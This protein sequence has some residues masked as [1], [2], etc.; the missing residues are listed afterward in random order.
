VGIIATWGASVTAASSISFANAAYGAGQTQVL[1]D[2]VTSGAVGT[3]GQ[4]S[5]LLGN[6][7]ATG[8]IA[9]SAEL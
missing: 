4:V 1:L 2:V 3:V 5:M 8:Y 9:V 7:S 6:N